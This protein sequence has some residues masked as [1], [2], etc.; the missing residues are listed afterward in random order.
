M[1]EIREYIFGVVAIFAT[2]TL[3]AFVSYKSELGTSVK[4]ACS[5]IVAAAVA[6]PLCGIISDAVISLPEIEDFIQEGA[7]EYEQ[8]GK[9]A[10]EGG[11]CRLIGEKFGLD[12]G[13]RV[14][15]TGFDF[16]TMS[17]EHIE[18]ILSDRAVLADAP[19]IESYISSLGI[20]ECRV[21]IEI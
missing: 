14:V 6:L 8:V 12:G 7:P 4:A 16:N 2:L 17:A 10:F 19:A 11:I 21:E 20:G 5:L 13:V 1:S 15:V 3:A 9:D 18:V